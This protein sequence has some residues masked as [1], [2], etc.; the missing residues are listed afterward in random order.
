MF[1]GVLGTERMLDPGIYEGTDMGRAMASMVKGSEFITKIL[2]I[3]LFFTLILSIMTAMAGSSRTLH[4]GGRD[5]W[6]PKY[7][8][9]VNAHGAPDNAMWTDLAVNMVLLLMSDYVFV[10]AVSNCNY[11]I[12]NFLSLNA[13]WIHRLDN[14][15]VPRPWRC[16]NIMMVL[17]TILAY[18]NAFLLGAGADVWG[19]GTLISGWVSAAF[20]V[21]VFLFRHYVTDRG[22]FPSDM[23]KDLLLPGQTVLGPK[24]AGV[25]PYLALAG[26]LGVMLLGYVIFWV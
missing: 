17:G 3:L 4:Q 21:P 7:L 9:Q 5:G 10:L 14:P 8:S 15:D 26:G 13:G 11:L 20:V 12:F 1:Q 18:V 25:L 2:I 16:P 22:Q 19:A 6:L 23:W 24:R